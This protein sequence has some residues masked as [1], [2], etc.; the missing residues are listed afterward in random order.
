M[1][2]NVTP[3]EATDEVEA[4][5]E[6]QRRSWGYLP[7]YAAAFVSRPEVARGWGALNGAIKDGMDHRR[8][9]LATIGAARVLKS[10]Y[11]NAAHSKFLRDECGDEN[12]MVAIAVG[13]PDEG[14]SVEDKAVVEL[15][16]KVARDATSITETDIDGMRELGFTDNEVA[17]IVFAAAARAF[18][19]KVI[20]SF[21]LQADHQLG[22]QFDP[23]VRDALVVGRPIAE[24]S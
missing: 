4:F 6:A 18:F 17:D 13:S 23:V 15:A 14:L 8:Y 19:T 10:T 5:L 24:P 12:A 21:G 20:D 3:S 1:L 11:C 16:A 22:E 2:I 7:N 9:E